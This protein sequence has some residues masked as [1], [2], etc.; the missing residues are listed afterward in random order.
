MSVM[1]NL[2]LRFLPNKKYIWFQIEGNSKSISEALQNP[3]LAS[4]FW[5][6]IN[7]KI[8]FDH[9]GHKTQDNHFPTLP[10]NPVLQLKRGEYP[11][12]MYCIQLCF[13][14]LFFFLVL[15]DPDVD[16]DV[17]EKKYIYVTWDRIVL[18]DFYYPVVGKCTTLLIQII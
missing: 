9:N 12:D 16:E 14:F 5:T 10:Q 15:N 18:F 1:Q 13:K 4:F 11:Y 3:S 2:I 7:F 8:A 6:S 17:K